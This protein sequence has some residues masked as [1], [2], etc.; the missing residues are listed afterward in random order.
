MKTAVYLRQSLDRDQTQLAVERQ[1]EAC[2]DLCKGKGWT[3][4]VMYVDNDT[5]AS[6]GRRRDYTQMLADIEAGA[7]GAVVCYR[8]DR[9]HRQPRGLEHFIDLANRHRVALATVTGDTDLGTEEGRL[10]ARIMGAVDRAEVEKKSARQKL[11]NRQR[12]KN[13]KAW[14]Q[15]TFGYDGDEIVEH[16]ADAIR[17]ACRDL[18][19]GASL[20]SIA[21]QWNSEGLKTA[22]GYTWTGGTVRQVL[23]RARN[24]GLQV[25]DGE[26][27]DGVSPTWPAI[28]K[29]EVWESVC[30]LLADPKRHTGKS[31][32]RKHLLTGIAIC[33]VCHKPM[34]TTARKTKGG[35]RVVYQC[36]RLGCMKIVR[37]LEKTDKRVIDS[38]TRRLAK[39]DAAVT[40]AKPTVDTAALRDKIDV[41]RAQIAEAEHDYD[42]GQIT[43]ARMNA[44]I[45]RVNEKLRPLEDKLLGAHMSR[46]VK[47]LA[48]KPDAAERFAKLP[49]D[50][51][52]G[53]I[54]TLAT[55]TIERQRRGGR[56]DPA[57][58]AV[59]WK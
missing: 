18:L 40:L 7:I 50:R 41:L 36:K 39:P 33:G 59:R 5:S 56:F 8:L 26:I 27:L 21:T 15:R 6:T 35:N 43:A 11:A 34:G 29:R 54:D 46:D 30:K 13:G 16:E 48:G 58:I 24:A 14:V 3:D 25:Y 51:R 53:V 4:T 31:Q 42:D 32:G 45:D 22:K 9:L 49:L 19:N 20:W 55:V 23:S 57:S 44:R 28:V 52:R 12:A 2:L 38:I 10:I 1:R 47:D 17:K 37:D